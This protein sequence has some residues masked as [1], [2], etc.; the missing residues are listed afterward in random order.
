MSG[1]EKK[2]RDIK[3]REEVFSVKE[4]PMIKDEDGKLISAHRCVGRNCFREGE[5][6]SFK[7]SPDS[8]VKIIGRI[9]LID[10][11]RNSQQKVA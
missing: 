6:S 4:K 10:E 9:V 3:A 7:L 5:K 1:M 8:K 11:K 2:Y